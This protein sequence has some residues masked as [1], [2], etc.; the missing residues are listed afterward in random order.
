MS[1]PEDADNILS[2]A[3]LLLGLAFVLCFAGYCRQRE[4]I[5]N[6][7]AMLLAMPLDA[8]TQDGNRPLTR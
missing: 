3:L 1:H 5:A 8:R 6:Y 2:L 4:Q 7:K